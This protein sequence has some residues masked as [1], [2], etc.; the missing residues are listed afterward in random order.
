MIV[1]KPGPGEYPDY[2]EGYIHK[3]PDGQ[4]LS[5]LEFQP[6]EAMLKLGTLSEENGN[7][8]YADGK[9]SLKEVLGHIND[10]ERIM[11]YR[12]LRIGRGDCTPLSGFDEELFVR[13]GHFDRLSIVQ[14][15]KDFAAVRNSTLSLV[16]QLDE[17]DW[18]RIGNANG[19]PVSARALVFIIA[20]HAIH[21][22]KIIRERYLQ[23]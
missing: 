6:E 18:Q 16:R 1:S 23:S 17:E 15:L 14:L 9:W 7:Y 3:V 22:F 5:L 20:G 10:T 11:S 2:F 19:G 12:L 13:H 21:H 8:K 4:L